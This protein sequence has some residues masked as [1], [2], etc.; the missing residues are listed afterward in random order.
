MRN[1]RP[2]EVRARHQTPAERRAI[3]AAVEREPLLPPGYLWWVLG[4]VVALGVMVCAAWLIYQCASA[5]QFQ[6]RTVRVH[7]NVL[8]TP[9]E[10]EGAAQVVGA[11]VFWV[12]R[13][14][15]AARLS[16]LPLVQHVEVVPALPDAVDIRVVERTPAGFWTIGDQSYLVD[17]EG[18][19]LKAVDAETEQIR[20]CAGQLCDPS[21]AALPS[22][23]QVDGHPLAPGDHVDAYALRTSAQLASLLPSVGVQPAGFAWSADTGLEV[24]TR[25][26]WRA[27]F[28]EAGNLDQQVAELRAIRDQ[29]TRTKT[30]AGLIDVRFGDRPYFQ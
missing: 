22:V 27:R 6:V 19:I 11:N 21:V 17:N 20:A 7:G 26:G 28:D 9:S 23:A 1:P 29:L 30:A 13:R 14:E 2:V 12:D 5:S 3:R 15:V 4:R 24:P 18:V 8:L 25:D 10:V 16:A